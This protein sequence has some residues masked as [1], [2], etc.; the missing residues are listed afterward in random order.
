MSINRDFYFNLKKKL[1][2]AKENVQHYRTDITVQ[3]IYIEELEEVS[4][5]IL[6]ALATEYLSSDLYYEEYP[7]EDEEEVTNDDENC[8][9]EYP[10]E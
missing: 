9:V 10:Q 7:E 4:D 1:E 3:Q 5:E 2:K 6:K 8:W